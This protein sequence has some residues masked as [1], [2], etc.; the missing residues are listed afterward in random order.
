MGEDEEG[1][2][3]GEPTSGRD[4]VGGELF[5]QDAQGTGKGV[6]LAHRV[7]MVLNGVRAEYLTT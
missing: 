6:E 4:H 5:L 3:V 2:E 1:S 7:V